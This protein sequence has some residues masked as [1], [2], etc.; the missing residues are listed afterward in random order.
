MKRTIAFILAFVMC[1]S[2]CA[3]GNSNDTSESQLSKEELIANAITVDTYTLQNAFY[4]NGVKAK[5]D[6]CNKPIIVSGT[7]IRVED[8][9]VIMCDSQVCVYVYLS[10]D[11]L[12]KIKTQTNISVVGIISDIQ[13]RERE[14]GG[15]TFT[16]PSYI[17]EYA[18]LI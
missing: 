2:L 16:E 10:V 1:L 11:D 9:Y 3:C 8:N 15:I 4:E 13:D 17:M 12:V 6:Y 5:Q 14:W 7:A 18:Y